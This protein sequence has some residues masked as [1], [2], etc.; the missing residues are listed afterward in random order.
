MAKYTDNTDK[1]LAEI[2]RLT[3]QRLEIAAQMVERTAKQMVPVK[4][5]TLKRS[6]T[7][8]IQKTKAIIGSNLN[9]APW[10]EMGTTNQSAQPYLR[11]ALMANLGKIKRLFGGN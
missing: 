7:H 1:I 11:P 9:Y 8:I 2:D 3:Q 10:I 4:T 6:I 5:G